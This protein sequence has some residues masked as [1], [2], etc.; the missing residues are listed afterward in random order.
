VFIPQALYPQGEKFLKPPSLKVLGFDQMDISR[1]RQVFQLIHQ[2]PIQI[3]ILDWRDPSNLILK[4]ELGTVQLGA[5][6]DQLAAQFNTL[7]QLRSL[8]SRVPRDRVSSIDLSNPD[9]PFLKLKSIAK[10]K[11]STNLD[12]KPPT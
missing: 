1:W 8:T 2:S 7:S 10:P 3:E 9:S 6:S 11:M 4:T 5:V 12:K